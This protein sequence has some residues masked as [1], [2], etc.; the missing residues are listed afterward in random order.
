MHGKAASGIQ[1]AER[2]SDSAA[3]AVRRVSAFKTSG[4]IDA[5][6]QGGDQQRAPSHPKRTLVRVRECAAPPGVAARDRVS[7]ARRV[8]DHPRPGIRQP[9]PGLR[10]RLTSRS[11]VQ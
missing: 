2:F 8:C 1:P 11:E 4:K 10:T 9:E 6:P 7:G 5:K 3:S